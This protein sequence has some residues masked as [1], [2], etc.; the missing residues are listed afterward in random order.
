[1]MRQKRVK[2]HQLNKSSREGK[3]NDVLRLK[4]TET[5]MEIRAVAPWDGKILKN[6]R[7]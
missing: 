6:C 7:F 3:E 4:R 1:M 5:D 2:E